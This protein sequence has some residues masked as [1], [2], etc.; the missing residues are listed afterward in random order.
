M[1]TRMVSISWP[2][3]PPASAT[4]SAGITG[5]SHRARPFFLFCFVFLRWSLALLPRLE[6]SGMFL[7]HCRLCLPGSS[8]SPASHSWGAEI[9]GTQHHS[10]LIFVFLVEMG[11]YY[12]G[13]AGLKLRTSWSAH[14]GLRKCWNY[15]VW[16]TIP[17]LI[18]SVLFCF[19]LFFLQ[20][21]FFSCYPGWSAMA[22]SRLT[23]T[24]ASWV[25]AILLP[26]PPEQLGLQA[27]ATMPSFFFFF[28]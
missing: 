4:Q 15:K 19:V 13:Q 22:R 21:E 14:L 16:A 1:L 12:V 5:L 20:M 27:R 18:L 17:G 24:S 2:R 25:Q 9:V 28:L 10:Q 11:F 6:C 7:A 3:D 23:A 8:N 26:Q